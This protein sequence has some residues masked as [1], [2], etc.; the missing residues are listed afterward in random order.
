MGRSLR[1]GGCVSLSYPL[2]EKFHTGRLLA[3]SHCYHLQSSF[4]ALLAFPLLHII[5]GCR[6]DL[7]TQRE[8]K[9]CARIMAYIDQ[10]HTPESWNYKTVGETEE[11]LDDIGCGNGF[12]IWHQGHRQQKRKQKYWTASKLKI[13]MCQRTQLEWIGNLW[14]GR[15]YLQITHI[16]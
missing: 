3:S 15:K 10:R 14:N 5:G 16:W 13:S 8:K 4:S 9:L 2:S 1:L 7:C 12:S 6:P 11:K